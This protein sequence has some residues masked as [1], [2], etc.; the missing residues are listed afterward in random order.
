MWKSQGGSGA[1]DFVFT[2]GSVS[3]RIAGGAGANHL[4][5]S[6]L[7]MAVEVA[8]TGTGTATGFAGTA[9]DTG[10]IADIT[11]LTGGR[12]EDQLTGQDADATWT[13][14]AGDDAYGSDLRTLSFR[15]VEN[16]QGGSGTDDFTVS[17]VHS[18]NLQGGSGSD[19]FTL[20]CSIDRFHCWRG[21]G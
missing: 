8:L 1:D 20:G 19:S 9:T 11:E 3:G 7:N 13:L 16:L 14:T 10:G 2:G 17:G 4:D 15:D 6:G 12:V 21:W 5:Y 18:G